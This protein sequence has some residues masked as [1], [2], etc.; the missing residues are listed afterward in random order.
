MNLNMKLE[1]TYPDPGPCG[2]YTQMYMCMCDLHQESYM[3]EVAWVSFSLGMIVGPS[4]GV[5]LLCEQ[6]SSV[7]SLWDILRCHLRG[8]QLYVA[9]FK[10]NIFILFSKMSKEIPDFKIMS[11]K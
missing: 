2:G 3:A 1:E 7:D 10:K 11:W 4:L 9:K 6:P 5:H 8:N